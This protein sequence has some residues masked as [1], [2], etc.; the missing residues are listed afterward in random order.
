MPI[1]EF[2]SRQRLDP[3]SKRFRPSPMFFTF[4]ATLIAFVFSGVSVGRAA[5]A[6]APK[7]PGQS[8]FGSDRYVEYIAGDLPIVL[9]SAHGGQL[10]PDAIPNRTSGV[11]VSDAY[12]QELARAVSAEFL[13]R[14]GHRPHLVASQLHRVKLDPNRE[15]KE[16]AQG[17][18]IAERAWH[19]FHGAIQ[20]ALRAAIARHGFAFLVDLHGHSHPI[21]RIELGYALDS[22]QLNQSDQAFDASELIS[23][24]TLRDLAARTGGSPSALVR[25]P[26]SLGDLF[27]TRGIRAVPSPE[28]SQP[29]IDPFFS[30]GYIVRHYAAAANTPKVDG[31]Q[32]ET[33]RVGLRDTAENR[34]RFAKVA[35]EA[36]TIFIQ[37]HYPY[38]FPATP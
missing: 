35:V 20:G 9:T 18:P 28:E 31:L 1:A 10:K 25:G 37:K 16:A 32:I 33:Y 3:R 6:P 29:G 14:T 26:N 36:L 4:L 38:T 17:D 23:L 19:E 5:T 13:A 7:N 22:K 15:I 11:T 30:G 12:T 27:A 2:C 21:P 24:S 34:A 8:Y